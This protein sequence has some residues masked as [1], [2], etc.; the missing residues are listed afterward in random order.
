MLYTGRAGRKPPFQKFVSY[1]NNNHDHHIKSIAKRAFLQI[2]IKNLRNRI[3]GK[4]VQL[5]TGVEIPYNFN[6][7]LNT[8]L[9]DELW[10]CRKSATS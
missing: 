5:D 6:R 8:E 1:S 3:N 9:G 10:I 4:G 7:N 2:L